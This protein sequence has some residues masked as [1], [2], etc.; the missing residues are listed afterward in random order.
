M[1]IYDADECPLPIEDDSWRK[2]PV[3]S[4]DDNYVGWIDFQQVNFSGTSPSQFVLKNYSVVSAMIVA[5]YFIDV[6]NSVSD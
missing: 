4:E 5:D 3:Y 6:C 2:C 1:I